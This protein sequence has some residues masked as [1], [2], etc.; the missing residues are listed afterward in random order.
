MPLLRR[1]TT[2]A[3]GY[4]REAYLVM[5]PVLGLPPSI[6]RL[7]AGCG[8]CSRANLVE[9]RLAM[10]RPAKLGYVFSYNPGIAGKDH[11]PVFALVAAPVQPGFTGTRYFYLDD[12]GVIRQ[13]IS[14]IVGPRSDPE[15]SPGSDPG[16]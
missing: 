1:V 10:A 6:V 13:A 3:A 4:H 11:V 9:M 12:G 16:Q 7:G 15:N 8:D 5:L 2:G 14:Q